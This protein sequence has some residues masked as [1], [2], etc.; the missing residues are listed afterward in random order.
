MMCIHLSIPLSGILYYKLL[1]LIFL[2]FVNKLRAKILIRFTQYSPSFFSS[3]SIIQSSAILRSKYRKE[4]KRRWLSS[5]LA[6]SQGIL[7]LINIECL[8]VLNGIYLIYIMNGI[9]YYF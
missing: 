9:M 1:I 3:L 6:E 2:F 7:H 4:L 8:R 5:R